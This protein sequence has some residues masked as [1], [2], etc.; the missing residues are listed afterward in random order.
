MDLSTI[1]VSSPV[2]ERSAKDM[3]MQKSFSCSSK[4]PSGKSVVGNGIG[5]LGLAYEERSSRDMQLARN[6]GC[7]TRENYQSL[8]DPRTER[9]VAMLKMFGGGCSEGY[10]HDRLNYNPYN[11]SS[12]V[13]YVPL[14]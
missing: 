1:G 7:G 14:R 11:S 12:N 3:A 9:D 10:T 5:A 6:F 13:V 2:D 8:T 4:F